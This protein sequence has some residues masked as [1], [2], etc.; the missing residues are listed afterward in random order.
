MQQSGD[1]ARRRRSRFCTHGSLRSP[2]PARALG[3]P[4][5]I[6]PS[7]S[8]VR[9]A[10]SRLGISGRNSARC[11]TRRTGEPRWARAAVFSAGELAAAAA[12]ARFT[13]V[14]GG[15]GRHGRRP[16]YA[17]SI[18]SCRRPHAHA[19][20]QGIARGARGDADGRRRRA[21]RDR[22]GGAVRAV[23]A[24][25]PLRPFDS[26]TASVLAGRGER[27]LAT[28]TRVVLH[29]VDP[30]ARRRCARRR[31]RGGGESA[32][33]RGRGGR[34]GARGRGAPG[35]AREAGRARARAARH[36][37]ARARRAARRARAS[38]RRLRTSEILA[39]LA[40]LLHG[41]PR[42]RLRGACV[43]A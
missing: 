18:S 29:V 16:K 42:S 4:R 21:L 24:A 26:H 38:R 10:W 34:A 11:S 9:P 35:R 3:A 43:P 40:S 25:R 14:V 36:R 33:R 19:S 37:E 20:W 31:A 2:P 23:S 7:R 6:S 27:R 30:R 12:T 32:R 1:C 17:V 13:S 8:R 28:A 41:R 22:R 39:P 15:L 5:A